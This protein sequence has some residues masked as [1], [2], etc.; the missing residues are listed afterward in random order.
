MWLILSKVSGELKL[1][2]VSTYD[3]SCLLGEVEGLFRMVLFHC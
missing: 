3:D 2:A 1:E